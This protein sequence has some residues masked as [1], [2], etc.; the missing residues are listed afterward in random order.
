MIWTHKTTPGKMPSTK[1]MNA[2]RKRPGRKEGS[3]LLALGIII[4]IIGCCLSSF[5]DTTYNAQQKQEQRYKE[6][7]QA[8]SEARRNNETLVKRK[9]VRRRFEIDREGNLLGEEITEKVGED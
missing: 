3:M 7:M 4:C 9:Q 2:A 8:L 6:L 1:N 5:E